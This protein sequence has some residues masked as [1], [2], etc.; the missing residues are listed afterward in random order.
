[1]PVGC[2]TVTMNQHVL[3]FQ[4]EPSVLLDTL[5]LVVCGGRQLSSDYL[6]LCDAIASQLRITAGRS[7]PWDHL[8]ARS[9]GGKAE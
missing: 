7:S 4:A 8:R 1:M 9:A 5:V 6:P 2:C 3:G